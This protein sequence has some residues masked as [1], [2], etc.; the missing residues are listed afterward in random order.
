MTRDPSTKGAPEVVFRGIVPSDALLAIVREQD[1]LMCSFLSHAPENRR[2]VIRREQGERM[3]EA[4]VSAGLRGRQGYGQAAHTNTQEAV[5][6]AYTELLRS[7]LNAD[8]A[9]AA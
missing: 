7:L 1:A 8:G 5:R 4:A 6:R 9:L 2:V 3:V